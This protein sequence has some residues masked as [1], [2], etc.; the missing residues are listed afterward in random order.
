MY[1]KAARYRPEI[2]LMY[3]GSGVLNVADSFGSMSGKRGRR[4]TIDFGENLMSII[5]S[6]SWF[7]SVIAYVG[8]AFMVVVM[9]M[10]VA[11]A[12][13]TIRDYRRMKKWMNEREDKN[14]VRKSWLR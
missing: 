12:I 2:Q 11:I 14:Y 13:M 9:I 7:V 5:D 4:M 1:C 3:I 10:I 8:L 6:T